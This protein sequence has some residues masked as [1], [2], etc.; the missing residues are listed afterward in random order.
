MVSKRT[1]QDYTTNF[2]NRAVSM[3]INLEKTAAQI[4]RNLGVNVT[5]LYLW[6]SAVK[7]S[8]SIVEENNA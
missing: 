2:R 8:D 7:S 1:K 5:I 3:V 6:V 4:A